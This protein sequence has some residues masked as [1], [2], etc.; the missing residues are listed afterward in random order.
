M[1]WLEALWWRWGSKGWNYRMIIPI[2]HQASPLLNKW[3][4]KLANLEEEKALFGTLSQAHQLA[5][6]F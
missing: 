1:I 2:V 4:K 5:H 3:T 6:T